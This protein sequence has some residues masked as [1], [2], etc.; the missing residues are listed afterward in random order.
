MLV[1]SPRLRPEDREHWNEISSADRQVART[2]A[3]RENVRRAQ[4]RIERWAVGKRGYVGVSW[5][6]DSTVL[7]DLCCAVLP[8]WPLVW[9]RVEPIFNPDCPAVRDVFLRRWPGVRYHEIVTHCRQDA[10]GIHATGT[11]QEGF[12]IAR[13]QFGECALSG[14]RGAESADRKRMRERGNWRTARRLAPLIDWPGTHV[15]A[16]L[17]DRDLPVHPAY[18]MA[19]GGVLEHRDRLRV[20]SLGGQRGRTFGREIQERIYY[21]DSRAY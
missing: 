19:F 18:A 3:H 6:K 20:S 5:G 14:I 7:A 15:W 4:D 2:R 11:L 13:K 16:Y 12:A 1:D 8:N 10:D 17:A 9:V 21:P